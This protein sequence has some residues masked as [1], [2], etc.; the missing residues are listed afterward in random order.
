MMSFSMGV[1]NAPLI[2]V[3]DLFPVGSKS[4]YFP[5]D[6]SQDARALNFLGF[7]SDNDLNDLTPSMGSQSADMNNEAGAWDPLFRGGITRFQAA[8]G[9]TVDSW[10]GPQTR[11][12]LA[13]NVARKNANPGALP[14]P[15]VNPSQPIPVT[16]GGVPAQPAAIPG[17]TPASTGG[18]AG[19]STVEMVGIGAAALALGGLAYYA[20]R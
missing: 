2:Y 3:P 15:P 19:L 6:V 18:A 1:I 5:R 16:P 7:L 20:M 10:V 14:P 13:A 11:T 12:A 8:M 9:L 17:V 4:A